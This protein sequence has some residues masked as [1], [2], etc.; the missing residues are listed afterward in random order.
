MI[1]NLSRFPYLGGKNNV[2][3]VM[4]IE[5][6]YIALLHWYKISTTFF[7]VL[8]QSQAF[9]RSAFLVCSCYCYYVLLFYCC[10]YK[11][12][13]CLL[14]RI[15]MLSIRK[16]KVFPNLEPCLYDCEGNHDYAT[17]TTTTGTQ[18]YRFQ[19]C[20]SFSY[21]KVDLHWVNG[22]EVESHSWNASC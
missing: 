5:I 9:H 11:S 7:F 19:C 10:V 12:L 17:Q 15:K 14:I 3:R 22:G 4:R 16:R 2:S 20:G 21:T 13:L 8:F 1:C 6:G 18:H